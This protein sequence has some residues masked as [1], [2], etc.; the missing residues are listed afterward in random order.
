ML[1]I[2]LFGPPGAGKGTQS[3]KLCE[4]YHLIHLS[5]GD[6]LRDEIA[7]GTELGLQA[8]SIMDKG[9]LVSDYIVIAIIDSKLD[10]NPHTKGFIFDGFP[11]TQA[12]AKALDELLEKRKVPINM[13]IALEVNDEE[14]LHRLLLRG[15]DSGRADDRDENVIRRRIFNYNN[16]T[17]PLKKYYSEQKKFHSVYGMGSVEN[18]FE[19][20]CAT[21]DNKTQ[22][23]KPYHDGTI[24][25][26]DVSMEDEPAKHLR[27][28]REKPKA[29]P[30]KK[31]ITKKKVVA[32]PAKKVAS[33]KKKNV[34][35]ATKKAKPAKK[36]VAKKKAVLKKIKT[37][38]KK[39]VKKTVVKKPVKKVAPK[40]A[41][42]KPIKK[43]PAKKKAVAKKTIKKSS[44]RKK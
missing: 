14:L 7:Q 27:T 2:V 3:K 43:S 30:V 25:I 13:M 44:K 4:A 33:L 10:A 17:A 5:T 29:K 40:R 1:N 34:K 20:L 31:I 12:Q 38:A 16:Q 22:A 37:V 28:V 19:L 35:H 36:V 8:K 42:A 26:A 18:I 9:E 24:T 21:I 39:I 41:K 6:L 32:K 15:V 23:N 11:R